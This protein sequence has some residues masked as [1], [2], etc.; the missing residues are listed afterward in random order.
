MYCDSV[1]L[2]SDLCTGEDRQ[3]NDRS[4]HSLLSRKWMVVISLND[5]TTVTWE[6]SPLMD[7]IT[8]DSLSIAYTAENLAR[9]RLRQKRSCP[10]YA[11]AGL[12]HANDGLLD[13]QTGD[14]QVRCFFC[15]VQDSAKSYPVYPF[16]RDG[17]WVLG[18]LDTPAQ[19]PP[20]FV[21][22]SR[23]D[24]CVKDMLDLNIKSQE[25][26]KNTVICFTVPHDADGSMSPMLAPM[27]CRKR[28]Y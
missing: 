8:A 6:G 22:D 9:N 10:S 7:K 16:Q 19:T 17:A 24:R 15:V 25:W 1:T 14:N 21:K 3:G 27:L 18:C 13:R 12:D 4:D 26:G 2:R 11:A 20:V 28:E 23:G 5:G